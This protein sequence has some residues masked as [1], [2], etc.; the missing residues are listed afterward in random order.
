MDVLLHLE[1]VLRYIKFTT[2]S[3]GV[4]WA[5]VGVILYY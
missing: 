5:W 4:K 2:L 1:G 3:V